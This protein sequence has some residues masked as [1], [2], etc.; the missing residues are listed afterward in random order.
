MKSNGKFILLLLEHTLEMASQILG[1]GVRIVTRSG[2]KTTKTLTEGRINDQSCLFLSIN[3]HSP[4][5]RQNSRRSLLSTSDKEHK[6]LCV[7]DKIKL[8]CYFEYVNFIYQYQENLHPKNLHPSNSPL[9]NLPW[10]TPTQK[11]LTWNIPTHVF[12]YSQLHF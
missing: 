12:Q 7:F 8:P 5:F 9:V 10:K 3:Y 4:F 1:L 11:I 2:E 6:I